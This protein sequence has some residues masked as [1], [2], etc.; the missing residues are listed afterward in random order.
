MPESRG[1]DRCQLVSVLLIKSIWLIAVD[2]Q[3]AYHVASLIEDR[4]NN[5]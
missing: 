3:Y 1:K 5:L 4:Q 2:I